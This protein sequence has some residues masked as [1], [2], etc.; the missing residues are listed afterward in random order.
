[1]PT[2]KADLSE[3][4][5]NQLC[6]LTGMTYRT[7]VKRLADV[8]PCAKDGKTKYYDP[9]EALPVLY[10]KKD[11]GGGGGDFKKLTEE[12]TRLT[13]A[14]ADKEELNVAVMRNEY[15]HHEVVSFV[16]TTMISNAKNRLNG[17]A[18]KLSPLV[19]MNSDVIENERIIENE[20]RAAQAEL[21]EYDPKQYRELDQEDSEDVESATESSGE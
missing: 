9:V 1:M 21:A 7:V 14:L 3:L 17:M 10:A 5:L 6:T 15:I 2:T 8:T 13:K 12:R 18:S 19:S 16:W 11:E 4:S 20:C